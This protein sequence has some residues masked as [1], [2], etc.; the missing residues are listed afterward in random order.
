[1]DRETDWERQRDKHR[2]SWREKVTW[3]DWE[4][5]IDKHR[6]PLEREKVK[7]RDWE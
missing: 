3:R 5:Q 1:M 7:R 4:R 2:A 6:A